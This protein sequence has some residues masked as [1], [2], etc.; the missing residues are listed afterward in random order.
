MFQHI[1]MPTDGSQ[2][3]EAAV[4]FGMRLAKAHG[5]RVTALSVAEVGGRAHARSSLEFVADVAKDCGVACD[6]VTA[7]GDTPHEH[8]VA[9]AGKLDCDLIVMATHAR[10]G[11]QAFVLGSQTQKVLAHS[12]VPVVVCRE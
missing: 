12:K 3:S 2:R 9:T 5:A 4:R 11:V 1:L 10:E 7:L 8:I 6:L